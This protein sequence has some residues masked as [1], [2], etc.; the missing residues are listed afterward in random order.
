MRRILVMALARSEAGKSRVMLRTQLAP[1]LPSIEGDRIQLQ[2]VM[3]NLI[4]NAIH[5]L[6]RSCRSGGSDEQRLALAELP[7]QPECQIYLE[8]TQD[9]VTKRL[10]SSPGRVDQQRLSTP[11]STSIASKPCRRS[12]AL[13]RQVRRIGW[14][15][16]V[17]ARKQSA[18]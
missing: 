7:H 11:H 18:R 12:A 1:Q 16:A 9:L 15:P 14:R 2:Q 17:R 6:Q 5:D 3:L 4:V 8:G 10:C 13:Q